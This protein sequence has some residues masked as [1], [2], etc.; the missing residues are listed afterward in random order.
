MEKIFNNTLSLND[1]SSKKAYKTVLRFVGLDD[2]A[3][4][5]MIIKKSFARNNMNKKL[6]NEYPNW[7]NVIWLAFIEFS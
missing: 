5:M 6:I 7:I 2:G 3:E 4:K 1:H